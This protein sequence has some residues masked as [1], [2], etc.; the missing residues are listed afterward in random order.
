M[1][2]YD[3]VWVDEIAER[4]GISRG[5]LYHYFPTKRDFFVAVTE[6]AASQVGELTEPDPTLPPQ[7]RLSAAIDRFLTFAESHPH[8]FLATYRGSLAGDPAVRAVVETAGN[9]QKERI[10]AFLSPGVEPSVVQRLAAQGWLAFAREVTAVWLEA[11]SPRREQIC[12]LLEDALLAA[13][14]A[15]T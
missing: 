1:R 15:A 14:R 10:L 11:R 5:L 6:C 12:R 3:E 9:R 4:A 7:E 8:G 13:F 2:G